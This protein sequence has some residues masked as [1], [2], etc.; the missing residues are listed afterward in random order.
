MMFCRLLWPTR[1]RQRIC[2]VSTHHSPRGWP[3]LPDSQI[4]QR[5]RVA[6][7]IRKTCRGTATLQHIGTVGAWLSALSSGGRCTSGLVPT[8]WS[9]SPDQCGC[10]FPLRS[11]CHVR[12]TSCTRPRYGRKTTFFPTAYHDPASTTVLGMGFGS[13]VFTYL[14][15]SVCL[16]AR[17]SACSRLSFLC[18]IAAYVHTCL[19]TSTYHIGLPRLHASA[20]TK[21]DHSCHSK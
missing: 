20:S 6:V 15:S 13:M 21:S 4:T 11:L 2:P 8:D 18:C 14:V 1:R 17:L 10:L 3:A 19:S 5:A 12:S 9:P 7:P 16:P